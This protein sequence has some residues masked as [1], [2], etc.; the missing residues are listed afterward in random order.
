MILFLRIMED[1]NMQMIELVQKISIIYREERDKVSEMRK[2]LWDIEE[3]LLKVERTNG[4]NITLEEYR[5]LTRRIEELTR[6]V[7]LKEQ[8]CEGISCVREMLMDLG[9][10]TDI[11]M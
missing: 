5:K 7:D 2:K 10:D 4:K 6:E 1:D 11:N 9:F 8:Y 3:E